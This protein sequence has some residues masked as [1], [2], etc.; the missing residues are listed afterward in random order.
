MFEC[1]LLF[2]GNFPILAYFAVRVPPVLNGS[3]AEPPVMKP[4]FVF[5][6]RCAIRSV[7]QIAVL[8]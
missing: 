3:R 7:L 4:I 5:W 8:L 6:R 2:Y 1:N